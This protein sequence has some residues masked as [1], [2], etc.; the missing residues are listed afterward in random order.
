MVINIMNTHSYRSVLLKKLNNYT[1]I[2]GKKTVLTVD[3]I[4]MIFS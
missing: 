1:K 4:N 2:G 3:K